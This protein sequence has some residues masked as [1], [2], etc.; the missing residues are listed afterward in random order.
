[1]FYFLLEKKGLG[2]KQKRAIQFPDVQ[3]RHQN[4]NNGQRGEHTSRLQLNISKHIHLTGSFQPMHL[5]QPALLSNA[6]YLSQ[7]RHQE[8]YKYRQNKKMYQ[9]YKKEQQNKKQATDIIII[10]FRRNIKIAIHQLTNQVLF[11]MQKGKAK[12]FWI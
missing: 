5:A 4:C 2:P 1:M 3:M 6:P 9:K 8:F 11:K 7:N 12:G 10:P